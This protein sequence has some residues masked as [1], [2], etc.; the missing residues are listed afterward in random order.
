MG[1]VSHESDEIGTTRNEEEDDEDLVEKIQKLDLDWSDFN[2][3][4]H[5]TCPDVNS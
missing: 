1:D 5:S 3:D 4:F 2:V